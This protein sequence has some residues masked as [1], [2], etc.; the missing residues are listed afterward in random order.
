MAGQLRYWDGLGEVL[1]LN[2]VLVDAD[3]PVYHYRL[4]NTNMYTW[5]YRLM[6]LAEERQ[7]LKG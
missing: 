5:S 1:L 3:T 2:T 4:P 6:P 7:Q